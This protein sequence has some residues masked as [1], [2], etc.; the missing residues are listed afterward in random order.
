L[1]LGEVTGCGCT[2]SVTGGATLCAVTEADHIDQA[3]SVNVTNKNA[4]NK[5]EYLDLILATPI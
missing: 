5:I 2:L 3:T 4:A 1:E